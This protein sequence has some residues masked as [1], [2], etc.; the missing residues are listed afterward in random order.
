MPIFVLRSFSN[1]LLKI[2]FYKVLNTCLNTTTISYAVQIYIKLIRIT[3]HSC[4]DMLDDS[5]ICLMAYHK[6]NVV[7]CHVCF[8][9]Y[10]SDNLNDCIYRKFEYFL[11]IHVNVWFT[12]IYSLTS[13]CFLI[14]C[15]TSQSVSH[16]GQT[17]CVAAL[18]ACS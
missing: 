5:F 14:S 9:Q 18:S 1:F 6:I 16:T 7:Q 10:I 12:V 3:F 2:S 17:I 4:N 13:Q 11:S 8:I 15:C